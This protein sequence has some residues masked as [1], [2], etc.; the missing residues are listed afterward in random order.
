MKSHSTLQAIFLRLA[1]TATVLAFL[2]VPAEAAA[3]GAKELTPVTLDTVTLPGGLTL[4][5]AETGRDR[6]QPVIFLHGYTDS[7]FSW[8]RVLPLLP[9][10]V[11]AYAI[12]QRGHGDSDKPADG[13]AMRDFSEDVIAF[14]DHFK[15]R[16]A[17]I[18]GHSMGSV[19]AQRLTIDHPERVARLVLVGAGADPDQNPVLVDFADFVDTLSDPLDRDFVFDFQASTVFS[20]VPEEFL[21]TVVDESLKVPVR[22]WQAALRGLVEENTLGELD[23]IVAPTLITWG[24]KD[25]VFPFPDQT[26]LR[27]GIRRSKLEVYQD[28]GHGLH[29]ER[30]ERFTADL[31]DVLRTPPRGGRR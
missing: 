23:R 18:V 22:V 19:I 9:P 13:Y 24:D 2:V 4:E 1:V 20:P 5:Y 7:W 15:I 25:E 30:P 3:P 14:M 26:E 17:T 6:G 28:T 27:D 11:H 29:W 21:D 16:R 8:S 31:L 12:T 10:R